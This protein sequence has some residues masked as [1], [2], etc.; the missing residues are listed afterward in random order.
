MTKTYTAH[1]CGFTSQ[2]NASLTGLNATALSV[3]ILS[4]PKII[5]RIKKKLLL[6]S[7]LVYLVKHLSL[8]CPFIMCYL[9]PSHFQP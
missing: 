3:D 2:G 6:E 1:H 7:T 4:E 5:R 8:T 9:K